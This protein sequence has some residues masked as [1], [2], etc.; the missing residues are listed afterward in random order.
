MQIPSSIQNWL[1]PNQKLDPASERIFMIATVTIPLALIIHLLYIPLFYWM[2]LPVLVIYNM[3]STGAWFL[4][5]H[6]V[7]RVRFNEAWCVFSVEILIQAILCVQYAG[8]SFGFQYYLFTLVGISFLLPNNARLSMTIAVLAILE[9]GLLVLWANDSPTHFSTPFMFTCRVI[10][11]CCAFS[12]LLFIETF[13]QKIILETE[14]KLGDAMATNEEL[15]QNVFPTKVL[16]TLKDQK[17]IIAERFESATVLFADIVDFTPLSEKMSAIELV[18]LLDKLFSRFDA[19]VRKHGLEK[20]KTIG[21][22]YMVAA[23]VPVARV[24]H[25]ELMADF[26]LDFLECLRQF[27]LENNLELKMRIGI[28]SG[29]VVAGVIG[30]WKFLYDL[31]GDCVN[32]AAR[33]EGHGVPGEIQITECTRNLISDVFDI[34]E[35][36]FVEIKGKGLMKTYLLKSRKANTIA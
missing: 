32:T 21:D 25:A 8:W 1:K 6:L 31:W 14:K 3:V 33:M 29:P 28:N 36:G 22:A 23:G 26:A 34:Q 18:H 12:I 13:H 20:I 7:R 10:N 9:F 5:L 2:G 15:L 11:S 4:V 30:K 17:G 35:R 27:N 19:L 24:N 16:Q